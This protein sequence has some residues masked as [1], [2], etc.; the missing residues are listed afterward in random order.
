MVDGAD[1]SLFLL[2]VAARSHEIEDRRD[3]VRMLCLSVKCTGKGGKESPLNY[4]H[5]KHLAALKLVVPLRMLVEVAANLVC[6][7]D[8]KRVRLIAERIGEL[9]RW[10]PLPSSPKGEGM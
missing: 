7:C 2:E 4:Q 8:T 6:C 5:T 10:S 3:E 9:A 1:G